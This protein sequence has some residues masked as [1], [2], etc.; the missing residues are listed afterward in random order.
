MCDLVGYNLSTACD[1]TGC[2]CLGFVQDSGKSSG[3]SK[4]DFRFESR[5]TWVSDTAIIIYCVVGG[6]L[7]L[8]ICAVC[9]L[10]VCRKKGDELDKRAY[11]RKWRKLKSKGLDFVTHKRGDINEGMTK[12]IVAGES[13]Q[14]TFEDPLRCFGE[15][16]GSKMLVLSLAN[17][18]NVTGDLSCLS[19]MTNARKINLWNCKKITGDLSSLSA[20]VSLDELQL[21]ECTFVTGKFSDLSSLTKLVELRL[22][23]CMEVEGNLSDLAPLKLLEIISLWNC[24]RVKGDLKSIESMMHMKV[25]NMANCKE[26]TGSLA[27]ISNFQELEFLN[28]ASRYPMKITGGPQ[29]LFRLRYMKKCNLEGLKGKLTGSKED[30]EKKLPMCEFFI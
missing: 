25:L 27:S 20:C 15:F 5:C 29:D 6:V 16:Y 19:A 9:L 7:V 23:G 14:A 18:A 26:I 22:A 17:C 10:R 2:S 3:K 11:E 28:L 12:F 4:C 13:V 1:C 21:F 30:F 8:V 24:Y